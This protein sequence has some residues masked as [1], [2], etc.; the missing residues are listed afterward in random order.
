MRVCLLKLVNVKRFHNHYAMI[1]VSSIIGL[2]RNEILLFVA[3]AEFTSNRTDSCW[4]SDDRLKEETGLNRNTLRKAKKGLID[5]ERVKITGQTKNGFDIYKLD[6]GKEVCVNLTHE[7][8][9]SPDETWNT[10][11]PINQVKYN[12]K[13]SAILPSPNELRE[14]EEYRKRFEEDWCVA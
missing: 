11:A 2:T 10:E 4:V 5:K 13:E 12:K 8:S 1:K 9:H 14:L 6:F 7:N 3:L